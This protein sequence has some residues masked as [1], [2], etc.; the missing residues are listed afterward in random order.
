L[1]PEDFTNKSTYKLAQEIAE[2]VRA[3]EQ[4]S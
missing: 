2:K 4:R 3:K 1:R